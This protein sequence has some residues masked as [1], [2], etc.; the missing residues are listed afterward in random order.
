MCFAFTPWS[1]T[2]C[3]DAARSFMFYFY[4]SIILQ[5]SQIQRSFC[6]VI[7]RVF[8]KQILFVGDLLYLFSHE[9]FVHFYLST[10]NLCPNFQFKSTVNN[11]NLLKPISFWP[12]L[13]TSSSQLHDF[14]LTRSIDL[15]NC[16][17]RTSILIS[18]LSQIKF[19][20]E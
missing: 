1:R 4:H 15:D 12:I 8:F 17:A 20:F 14:S 10:N 19:D 7:M 6:C 9:L 16:L 11:V 3:L 2:L 18:C 13:Q 5:E